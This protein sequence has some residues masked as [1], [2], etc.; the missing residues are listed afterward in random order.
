M[1]QIASYTGRSSTSI[2][3][4]LDRWGERG[5]EGLADGSAPGNPPRISQKM[6]A[7]IQGRLSEQRTWNATQLAEGLQEEFSV[8]VTPEAVRQHLLAM[9]YRWKR[10]CYTPWRE[11]DPGQDKEAR[12]ELERLKRGLRRAD[13]PKIP[14]RERFLLVPSAHGLLDEEGLRPSASRHRA[15]GVQRTHKPHRHALA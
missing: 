15:M 3:R 4:D 11:P 13:R 9:G 1:A 2:A 10:T 6:R 7:Y 14:R 5:M 8:S 12:E